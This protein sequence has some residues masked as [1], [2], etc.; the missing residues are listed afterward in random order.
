MAV[1]LRNLGAKL[2]E[3]HEMA[4]LDHN[5]VEQGAMLII[6]GFLERVLKTKE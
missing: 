2:V 4:G 5:A 1:T 6:P 3:F